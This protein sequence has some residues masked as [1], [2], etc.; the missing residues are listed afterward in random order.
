[1]HRIRFILVS[2]CLLV[3]PSLQAQLPDSMTAF[4]AGEWG[5]GFVQARGLA[6]GGVLRFSTPTRAWV[7]DGFATYD[8]QIVSGAG[9]F[10][11]DESAHSYNINASA[12]PRWFH[13]TSPRLVRIVG[14]GVTAGYTSTQLVA[15]TN[16]DRYW[17]AGVY[18]EIGFQY[19]FS[20]HF[21]LGWRGNVVVSRIA[22][23]QTQSSG[24]GGETTLNT[25]YYHLGLEPVQLMGTIYF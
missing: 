20:R 18:G 24:L 3:A 12:G 8:K 23:R 19:M 13:A 1:M 22:D 6:E 2:V 15:S 7:L 4:R 5:V 21:G 14:V 16:K 9:I 25:T 17:S 11:S 10:G